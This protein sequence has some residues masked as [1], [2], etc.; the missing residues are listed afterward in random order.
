MSHLVDVNKMHPPIPPELVKLG[1]FFDFEDDTGW[2]FKP[3]GTSVWEPL[4]F[5]AKRLKQ[6]DPFNPLSLDVRHG[7]EIRALCESFWRKRAERWSR[8]IR[9]LLSRTNG[10]GGVRPWKYKTDYS[11][12]MKYRA[13]C[14]GCEKHA[15][16]WRA[17]GLSK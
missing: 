1:I 3:Q 2:C 10:I 11:R 12:A 8:L 13:C 4:K 6:R 7:M 16:A 9:S 5:L 17:W 14:S 15:D